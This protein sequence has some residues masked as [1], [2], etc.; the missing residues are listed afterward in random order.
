MD[1]RDEAQNFFP[2]GDGTV[3]AWFRADAWPS[4][5]TYL[6]Q[7]FQGYSAQKSA[8][9]RSELFSLRY[10][11]S[12]KRL[13]LYMK[14]RQNTVFSAQATQALPVGEWVHIAAQW[15]V[16]GQARVFV[17]GKEALARDITG[18]R[19][20]DLS[21][22][23][24]PDEEIVT[25][26]FLGSTSASARNTETAENAGAPFFQ[27]AV[28]QLRVS[29]GTR[30][31]GAFTPARRHVPDAATR[32]LFAFDRSYDG[33]SGGGCRFIR[34]S[35]RSF[36]DRVRHTLDL[37]GNE[38]P[39]WPAEI[40]PENDH[41]QVL[42]ID[43]YPDLPTVDEFLSARRATNAVFDVSPGATFTLN[44]PGTVY[45]DYVEIANTGTSPL[46]YPTVV[47]AG[48]IDPRSFGD[49]RD[50]L[51]LAELDDRA[52]ANKIFQF[53]LGASDYFMNHSAFFAPGTDTPGD[54]EYQALMM[55]NGY[56]GFECGPLNSMTKNL[57][58]CSGGLPSSQTGGYGHSFEQVFY[59]GK[60]HI[61]DLSAQKFFPAMDNETAAYLE[62]AGDQPGIF[63][64]IGGNPDHFIRKSRRGADASSPSFSEKVAMSLNP[65]E[66]LRVWFDNDGEGNDLQCSKS[67]VQND[68][69]LHKENYDDRCHAVAGSAGSIW[70]V[71]RHFPHYGNGFLVYEGPVDVA[72]PAFAASTKSS[73]VYAVK[74]CY[75]IT[76][77]EYSAKLQDGTYAPMQLSTDRGATW[78]ALPAG[79]VR[80]PVRAR[81][82]YLVRA[83][84]DPAKVV[85]FS[86]ITEVQ[87][88]VRI[89]TGGVHAGANALTFKANGGE[90][91]RVTL[92]WR[93]P[94]KRLEIRG[95][96]YSGTIPGSERQLVL[97][98]PASTLT[99]DVAGASEQAVVRAYGGL[100]ATLADGRL[101][102]A[103]GTLA[104]GF[105]AVDVIDG[106]AVKQF[107]V[108]V[109]ANARLATAAN[110]GLVPAGTTHLLQP[111]VERVQPCLNF[112]NAA[113]SATVGFAELP[114]GKYA[115]LPL[116]RF[117]SH[118][119]VVGS[120]PLLVSVP[121]IAGSFK[122]SYGA[123]GTCTFL[124]AQYGKAGVTKRANFKWGHVTT[125]E[126]N[127]YYSGQMRVF[128][129]P[130]AFS[131]LAV[132]CNAT[133]TNGV[134]LA[135]VLVA[136]CDRA[137]ET[138]ELYCDLLKVLCGYNCQ[139]WR[140]NAGTEAAKGT[141]TLH[142]T[143]V[144]CSVDF[145]Y[146]EDIAG[147]AVEY[148]A[149]GANAAWSRAPRFPRFTDKCE[150]RGSILD[151]A[152]DTAYEV[153]I[154]TPG[155]AVLAHDTFR[156]WRSDVPV[157]RT[158]TI[159][160]A[161]SSVPITISARGT[162]DG[163][164][165]YV[166]KPGSVLTNRTV[167]VGGSSAA[168]TFDVTGARNVLLDDMRLVG[169]ARYVIRVT[170]SQG[171][172][173]RNCD[174]SG[175]GRVG[176]PRYDLPEGGKFYY[177]YN[178]TT[179]AINGDPAIYIGSGASAVTVERCYVH[180][181]RGHA[182]SWY[183]SHPA[184][185]QAV[186]MFRPDHSVVL[187]WNDFCGG[188]WH[189]YN[190]VV[191]GDG[192]FFANGGFNRDADV[193]GNYM[194]FS[195]DDAIELDGGQRNV[196]CFD[197]RFEYNYCG[198]SVQGCMTSPSYV[199][200]N[201]FSGMCDV[202]SL[203]GQTLK[204]STNTS[205]V[206]AVTYVWDNFMWGGGSGT[207]FPNASKYDWTLEVTGN[208]LCANQKISNFGIATARSVNE[209]NVEGAQVNEGQLDASFP[210]RSLPFV[211]DR[212][213]LTGPR[214]VGGKA[215]ASRPLGSVDVGAAVFRWEG[216][217]GVTSHWPFVCTA[218]VAIST[219]AVCTYDLRR[220]L[221]FAADV[222]SGPL[223]FVKTGPGAMVLAGDTDGTAFSFGTSQTG[224]G[225]PALPGYAT[226]FFLPADGS[227]PTTGFA[228]IFSLMDGRFVVNRGRM[229]VKQTSSRAF[230]GGWTA[231][232][233]ETEK[234]VAF[235]VNGGRVDFNTIVY[236]GHRHGLLNF[237][238]PNGPAKACLNVNG[239]T[240]FMG[241][242]KSFVMGSYD[243]PSGRVL[244]SDLRLNVGR[245]GEFA[246]SP[247]YYAPFSVPQRRG[248]A[249]AITVNGG[250]FRS[251]VVLVG[252]AASADDVTAPVSVTVANGG[253]FRCESF[254]NN[255]LQKTS[256]SPLT[257]VVGEGGAFLVDHFAN[258][259]GGIVD[260]TVDGG[261][262]GNAQINGR[263]LGARKILAAANF[264]KLAV[265]PKGMTV[266]A[267]G[268]TPAG[269]AITCVVGTPLSGS[270]PI[271]I[272]AD[273][274]NRVEFADGSAFEGRLVMNAG[275]LRIPAGMTLT[276]DDI[277]GLD[278]LE[279]EGTLVCQVADG[280]KIS[281]NCPVTG[282][283][284]IVKTGGGTLRLAAHVA[285][286]VLEAREGVVEV[287]ASFNAVRRVRFGR[288]IVKLAAKEALSLAELEWTDP[289]AAMDTC[290]YLDLNG[291]ANTNGVLVSVTPAAADGHFWVKNSGSGT[292]VWTLVNRAPGTNV[293][294]LATAERVRVNIKRVS[295][296]SPR[297][298][299]IMS[300]LVVR[301]NGYGFT[302][303][304]ENYVLA[305]DCHFPNL[306]NLQF[307]SGAKTVLE[308]ANPKPD[309]FPSLRQ[310]VI[311]SHTL[312]LNDRALA[313]LYARRRKW[314][315]S[316]NQASSLV[317]PPNSRLV[318]A[319]WIERG[320][321]PSVNHA[322]GVYGP[323]QYAE[324]WPNRTLKPA[325]AGI[326]V[327]SSGP[328]AV[329]LPD[330]ANFMFF[331]R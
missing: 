214:V 224:N 232:A 113:S 40:L 43:N 227:M 129:V 324:G 201:L 290:A 262:L 87:V 250:R 79:K 190:D 147:L 261:I 135:A 34:G 110:G 85:R 208:V 24:Y 11:H 86:A 256:A 326:R 104:R 302:A 106:D 203:K 90:A 287:G 174:L 269:E 327:L 75:P 63:H 8:N 109:L 93:E 49:I 50:T 30:Y 55:L 14:D 91:A 308:F 94:A 277:S 267:K 73:A 16:N 320:V 211:L 330:E 321:S 182:N 253:E 97:L 139:P 159:D 226:R 173:I 13:Y 280:A 254:T 291:F 123:N 145:E 107:T 266:R 217:N 264:A 235:E 83:M 166:L 188:D 153:R 74:S 77:A 241:S 195:Q 133:V 219:N 305:G 202:F 103:A 26:F 314:T 114:A 205:G 248:Q 295:V 92:G 265:G 179:K 142:P 178:G 69:A 36:A 263:Q 329:T 96:V 222:S 273:R 322:K 223:P 52:C 196:R 285:A 88:N 225:Y 117:E 158:V 39:Y 247:Q 209:G 5:E 228:G 325:S 297:G 328:G 275:A 331:M 67:S 274:G 80:Y 33:E 12:S 57:F 25:E 171:V 101:T 281:L 160:P 233:G 300:N 4:K 140:V 53:V 311:D 102:L 194:A 279:L 163:W 108:L 251:N 58:T 221:V 259:P 292:V 157:A 283:G 276:A 21:A 136:P 272:D 319:A 169:G 19:P 119:A 137:G 164:I 161:T 81:T 268:K 84:A 89:F 309:A 6:F 78:R 10:T 144:N 183:Y 165:R 76:A 66:R 260:M 193:Y 229:T 192:N 131:S 126:G 1:S 315:Y 125:T 28:D 151:L 152:E 172:R 316:S 243:V 220:D 304:C 242:S 307:N 45:R 184:G 231:D 197:N 95:G 206:D 105:G 306:E 271:T 48:E 65:G 118:P 198:V 138:E 120:A 100:S 189:R 37:G 22:E 296:P 156:T 35:I 148:R 289:L 176:V 38:V 323:E 236:L 288:G 99:L 317:L 303:A 115:V 215:G 282:G 71:H 146:A 46:L 122:M 3:E 278:A 124:K 42:N 130:Q 210:R 54:V 318:A 252:T 185:P 175:W 61:Y 186:M 2:A 258:L 170:N 181:P 213:R 255:L 44:L 191:E 41:R 59:D 72:N 17:N 51:G 127:S 112:T 230:I 56:C 293:A 298:T 7:G 299:Q 98:D 313:S 246:M 116:D 257:I 286:D 32:A 212:A 20:V 155:G 238:T 128:D 29:T 82:E 207:S 294:Y 168:V 149:A 200:R 204:T 216:A 23:Q 154:V 143:Y 218:P 18:F 47:N 312:T 239:G 134:E 141:L 132:S 62:E 234:D 121:G 310:I 31:A 64:R 270:G 9:G 177:D 187:R 180:D 68:S 150:N 15:S 199:Y 70:R 237:N 162:E 245:D 249:A 284:R 111:D 167:S 27:G 60:N 244:N 301:A 240:F